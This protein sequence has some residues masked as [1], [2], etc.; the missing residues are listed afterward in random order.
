MSEVKRVAMAQF[1]RQTSNVTR[2]LRDGECSELRVLWHGSELFSVRLCREGKKIEA[3]IQEL[4]AAASEPKIEG[5]AQPKG[6]DELPGAGDVGKKKS[7][8]KGS[9]K[10][11]GK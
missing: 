7:K 11:R 1:I 5:K 6:K 8:A 4:R 9:K 3:R 2:G 10:I